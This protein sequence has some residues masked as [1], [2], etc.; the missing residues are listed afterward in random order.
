M[1]ETCMN[2]TNCKETIKEKA[3]CPVSSSPHFFI[4]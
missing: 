1:N 3:G 4:M 2:E